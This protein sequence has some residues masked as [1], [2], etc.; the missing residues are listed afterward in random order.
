METQN[1]RNAW[2]IWDINS[3]REMRL[4]KRKELYQKIINCWDLICSL[5]PLYFILILLA[6]LLAG[7]A[8]LG[9]KESNPKYFLPH[10]VYL[11]RYSICGVRL[12]LSLRVIFYRRKIGCLFTIGISIDPVFDRNHGLF[13]H[14]CLH[15]S[16]SRLFKEN[17]ERRTASHSF[18]SRSLDC[19][20][21]SFEKCPSPCFYITCW[22]LHT[23]SAL[24][25]FKN[26]PYTLNTLIEPTPSSIKN[27]APF[28]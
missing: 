4:E 26:S 5:I 27:E 22:Y 1:D 18:N 28:D 25:E 20:P 9:V 19:P 16:L 10:L 21:S 12:S 7:L 14:F 24:K 8:L 13:V 3:T 11:Y 2:L 6:V 23:V 17:C 15:V